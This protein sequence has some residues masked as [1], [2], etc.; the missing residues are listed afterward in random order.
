[1][2]RFLLIGFALIISTVTLFAQFKM[3]V[4]AVYNVPNSTEFAKN[5]QNGYGGTSEI[6]YFIKESGFSASLLFGI[7][8]FRASREYEQELADSNL[9]VFEYDYQIN[10]YTFPLLLSA[11]YTFLREKKINI[12]LGIGLGGNF[13]EEKHKQ[14]GEYTSDTEKTHFNEFALYPKLGFSFALTSDLA[15]IVKGGYNIT[16]GKK[17]IQ[18]F[19][20]NFGLIYDL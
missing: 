8:G 12:I 19:D 18:Y 17:E 15:I 16:F 5:F 14:I 3:D 7:N 2:R 4:C 20:I 6:H 1:M 13:M 10:Y 9:T 11:N